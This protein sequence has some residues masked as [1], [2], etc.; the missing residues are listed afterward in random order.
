MSLGDPLFSSL[1]LGYDA[2]A[3]CVGHF[4]FDANVLSVLPS[5]YW[6][7]FSLSRAS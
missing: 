5:L 3:W 1:G 2:L 6:T 4:E 7:D